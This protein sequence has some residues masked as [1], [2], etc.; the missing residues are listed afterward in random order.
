MNGS[1]S[2][3]RVLTKIAIPI[4]ERLLTQGEIVRISGLPRSARLLDHQFA[5][6]RNEIDLVFEDESF[7]QVEFGRQLPMR[8]LI[9]ELI[10]QTEPV[11]LGSSGSFKGGG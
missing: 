6:E 3:R 8:D 2:S 5:V 10:S 9:V 7:D 1:R 11:E 4:L